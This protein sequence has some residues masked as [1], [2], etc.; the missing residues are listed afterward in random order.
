MRRISLLLVISL[1]AG[2]SHYI[3]PIGGNTA[4]LR[5]VSLPGNPTEIHTLDQTTCIGQPDKL[6]AKLGLNIKDGVNQGRSLE[7]NLPEG[8]PRASIA[9]LRIDASTPSA[10]RIKASA[11]KGPRG[12]GWSYPACIKSFRLTPK[13][14]EQYE[15]QLEQ[16]PGECQINIFRLSREKDGSYVR[17]IA[18]N[19]EP[20]K[21]RC[22]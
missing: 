22:H 3:E 20:L 17:R 9:E 6:V 7:M 5:I 14:D 1:L 13:P 8:L 21:H 10:F 11:A 4:K 12:A 19:A 16:Q 18:S 2:C 15:A